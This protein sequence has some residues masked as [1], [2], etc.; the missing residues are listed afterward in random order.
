MNLKNLVSRAAVFLFTCSLV[1]SP[2][3]I[4]AQSNESFTDALNPVERVEW[5]GDK[6]VAKPL[7]ILMDYNDYNHRELLD[8]ESWNVNGYTKEQMS[9]YLYSKQYYR[10]RFFGENTYTASDGN[11]Y[12][13]LK[14]FFSEESGGS[15]VFDGDVVGWYRAENNAKYYGASENGSDQNNATK[16]V[17]EALKAAAED[18]TVDLS[19]YDVEDKWDYDKDGNYFEP[20]GIVDTLVVIHSGIGE[21]HGGGILGEDAIWPFRAK[22][23]WYKANDY[24]QYEVVDSQNRKWKGEDYTVFSQDL[25]LDLFGHEYGHVLGLD[26]LYDTN[27][28]ETPVQYWSLMGGSYTGPIRGVMPNSYGAYGREYFQKDFEKK[29][30]ILNWQKS[31]EISIEELDEKGVDVVLD[32]ASVKGEGYNTIRVSL[33]KK[34]NIIN[35]PVDGKYAYFSGKG[36][37]L[38]NSMT[39][40]VDL[41]GNTSAKLE[42][43][44]WYDIDPEFDYA[45]VQVREKGSEAWIPIEGTITT[46]VNPNDETPNDSTDRNP[47]HGITYDSAGKWVFSR[48][49]LSEFAGKEIE[50][51]IYW[52]T[53]T[54]TPEEG[55]YIDYIKLYG[56]NE[57]ILYDDAEGESKFN[58]DGFRISDGKEFSEHYYL[59][60][61]RNSENGLVDN[62]LA[63]FPW[64]GYENIKYDAGLVAWYMNTDKVNDRG[65][66]DQNVKEHPG[67]CYAAVVD[68]D[69]ET[70]M[71]WYPKNDT[72]VDKIVFQMHDAAFGLEKT[73]SMDIHWS[74]GAVTTDDSTFMNPVF[75]DNK[76]YYKENVLEAG[77]KLP[78][79]GLK[80]FVVEESY[81]RSSAKVHIT[82][83]GTQN[84][85]IQDSSIINRIGIRNGK[86]IMETDKTY[87]EK[88]Y[89][90]CVVNGETKKLVLN[91][92]NDYYECDLNANADDI[93]LNFVVLEDSIG[94]S[95]AFYNIN[96]YKVFGT[97][98][99]V[100]E[101]ESNNIA[102]SAV[103][104]APESG[105]VG[106]SIQFNSD[107]SF[108]PDGEIVRFLWNF[109]DGETSEE[110][111]PAHIFRQAG[112]F[113]VTLDVTDNMHATT[114]QSI[115]INI[116][117]QGGIIEESEPNNGFDKASGPI[118][119]F[120]TVNGN[121]N[122]ED[123]IDIYYFDVNEESDIKI[124]VNDSKESG[125]NWML[126]KEGN[127]DNYVAYPNGN[128][129]LT[130]T[131]H[132]E[133]GRYYLYF[134]YFSGENHNYNINIETIQ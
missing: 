78:N 113:N 126:Y 34:E 90:S 13:T 97:D 133:A 85:T 77:V 58:L 46:T 125:I 72:G 45:S 94:N 112:D 14:K 37:N 109:G 107:K 108:D 69:Q 86:L 115:S 101:I 56:D 23:S 27:G 21:E 63:S 117:G 54:N 132:A 18:P 33:S 118:M 120:S 61:W 16:L 24:K 130:G 12:I 32:Q 52:W 100:E 22:I 9:D 88:A 129:K 102:P 116:E 31:K 76:S 127:F 20:D 62:G 65:R 93:I 105:R 106:E 114:S 28:S 41:T 5:T 50:L 91:Q 1:V 11:N 134:Y 79:L 128:E 51:K 36:D 43:I 81:N 68:A 96:V 123:T 4:K 48:F 66:A 119:M 40:E 83:E 75:E 67:E 49:N 70:I 110:K 29:G 95:K 121:M 17:M 38:K 71:W 57:V 59:L 8:K 6:V 103:I 2:M 19:K 39:T 7:V 53:D 104:E 15:Y 3:N 44:A 26:D 124:K 82:K 35:T 98:M 99:N 30:K 74:N 25:P 55:I 87:G 80:Y 122:S 47:G 73:S 111:N 84:P 42:F 131:Y 64:E 60:E 89:V 92:I 10:D